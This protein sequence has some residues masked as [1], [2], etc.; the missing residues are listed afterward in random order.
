MTSRI[1][2]HGQG[3]AACA[4]RFCCAKK[5]EH[6][7][8]GDIAAE[9]TC[10]LIDDGTQAQLREFQNENCSRIATIRKRVVAW[11]GA[12]A[13]SFSFCGDRGEQV[14]GSVCRRLLELVV[15]DR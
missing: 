6:C 1:A 4:V 9:I 15:I 2:I 11:N 3:I 13:E 12:K 8:C 14:L 5:G 7:T 10:V